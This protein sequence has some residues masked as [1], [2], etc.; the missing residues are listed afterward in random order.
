MISRIVRV[1]TR[2]RHAC[3]RSSGNNGIDNGLGLTFAKGSLTRSEK[4]WSICSQFLW[5]CK[6]WPILKVKN[7]S[8]GEFQTSKI[9]QIIIFAI[10]E[11]LTLAKLK[12][13]RLR[14]GQNQKSAQF[15]TY[16]SDFWWI[17]AFSSD[18]K[19]HFWLFF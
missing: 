2:W 12:F 7:W 18:Q 16:K 8:F 11:G 13:S 6:F 4:N 9:V 10:S 5:K 14:F 19:R 17:L 1:R 3:D 15:W